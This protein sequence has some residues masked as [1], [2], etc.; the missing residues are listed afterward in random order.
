MVV[1]R[2]VGGPAEAVRV[3]TLGELDP[4]TVDMRCLLIIGS[5]QTR[6]MPRADGSTQVYTPRHYPA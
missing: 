4:A 5:C 1:G 2:D 6:V 3:T